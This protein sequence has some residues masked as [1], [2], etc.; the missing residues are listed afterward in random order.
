MDINWLLFRF[1]QGQ[2]N[3]YLSSIKKK[4]DLYQLFANMA[5]NIEESEL[6]KM[7]VKCEAL[8]STKK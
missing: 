1:S 6:N 8:A 4:D 2:H 3:V 7:S 5:L